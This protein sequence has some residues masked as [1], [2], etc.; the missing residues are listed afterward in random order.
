MGRN[1]I[2]LFIKILALLTVASG[3]LVSLGNANINEWFSKR[4]E[5]SMFNLT[6][7]RPDQFEY[8]FS[9]KNYPDLPTWMSFMYS[10]EYNAGF[11]YGTPP[12]HLGGQEV[13][14]WFLI[15]FH[16]CKSIFL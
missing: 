11:L 16:F 12:E 3:D 9:L 15:V 14:T 2:L 10:T 5:P 1:R 13:R 4:I 6:L 8:S 7:E